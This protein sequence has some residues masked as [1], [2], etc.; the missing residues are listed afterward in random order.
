M[1]RALQQSG[2]VCDFELTGEQIELHSLVSKMEQPPAELSFEEDISNQVQLSCRL[3]L[4]FVCIFVSGLRKL[5]SDV[6]QK[7]QIL[8]RF[9]TSWLA[10]CPMNCFAIY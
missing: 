3:F 8:F 1:L 4:Y 9:P 7:I 5:H 2:G 10:G 6:L